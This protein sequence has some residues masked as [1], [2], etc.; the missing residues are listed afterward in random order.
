[1]TICFECMRE[2]TI[3]AGC[4]VRTVP[5]LAVD[6]MRRLWGS[7]PGWETAAKRPGDRCPDCGVLPGGL[8]H[9][10]CDVEECPACRHQLIS[11]GCFGDD[12]WE[13]DEYELQQAG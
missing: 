12:L 3:A 8:H 9:L 5:I 6:H 11:C 2:M 7:E 4:T 13:L 1:M 10:G